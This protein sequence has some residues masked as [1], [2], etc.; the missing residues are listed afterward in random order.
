MS[1][2]FNNPL[3]IRGRASLILLLLVVPL[4][5]S[6]MAGAYV[7]HPL[8]R[9]GAPGEGTCQDCHDEYQLNYGDGYAKMEDL[10]SGYEPGRSYDLKVVVYSPDRTRFGFELT[11]VATEAGSAAGSFACIDA[12]G[13]CVEAGGK[14]IKTTKGCLDVGSGDMATWT[15]RW[16]SPSKAESDVTFYLVGMGSDADNDEDGDLTYTCMM[17]LCPAPRSPVQPKGIIVEPGDSRTTLTWFLDEEPDPK[18]GA[19]TYT[20]YWSDSLSGGLS[21]LT[22]TTDMTHTHTGLA[23]G[24]TYRYQISAYNNEGEGPL[25][26]V[27]RSTPNLVPDRPRHLVAEKVSHEEIKI[28]WDAP[29]S[30]GDGVQQTYT[31]SRGMCPCM[32]MEIAQGVTTPSYVDNGTLMANTTYY[33]Q[34]RAVSSTGPGGVVMLTTHV[35]VTTPSFPLSLNVAVKAT[36]VELYWEPPS[37]EG[38]DMVQE[39]RVYRAEGDGAPV[40]LRDHVMANEYIDMDVMPDVDYEYTVAA[41]NGAGEGALS[42][43]VEAYIYPQPGA[44]DTGGVSFEGIPFSGLVAVGAVI[45]IGAVMVGR[46]GRASLEA[47]RREEE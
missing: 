26:T 42:T 44:G 12:I 7:N 16:N 3:R 43:P 13:T 4:V 5:F 24:R 18:G 39:Y 33:Y 15:V 20:I 45:I 37:D 6:L 2:P 19:V 9:T 38:G 22:T 1:I 17:T 10:P 41:I 46:L 27:V 29:S 30:W 32:M 8:Y 40:L 28:R 35:P 21:M 14:Y 31:V 25:S 11:T 23:N 36:S 47:E 34:V